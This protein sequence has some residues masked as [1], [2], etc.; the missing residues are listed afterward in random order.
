ME[1]II[2][3]NKCNILCL[4]YQQGKMCEKLKASDKLINLVNEFGVSKSTMV[5]NIFKQFQNNYPKMKKSSFVLQFLKNNFKII[6][7]I[8]RENVS[9]L[10]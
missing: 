7:D 5:F 6:K 10:E 3:S 9:D 4:A 2:K 1:K 8:C